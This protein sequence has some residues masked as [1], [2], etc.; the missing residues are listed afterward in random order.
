[1]RKL[2][3]VALLTIVGSSS[4]LVNTSFADSQRLDQLMCKKVDKLFKEAQHRRGPSLE[5]RLTELWQ[6]ILPADPEIEKYARDNKRRHGALIYVRASGESGEKTVRLFFYNSST[7][8]MDGRL[9]KSIKEWFLPN[10]I[11]Q[12]VAQTVARKLSSE[13]DTSYVVTVECTDEKAEVI[14]SPRGG[15]LLRSPLKGESLTQK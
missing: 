3:F 14:L 5:A 15:T 4:V 12:S 7:E 10:P 2:V 1:M 11:A 8:A 9:N 6:A 13:T